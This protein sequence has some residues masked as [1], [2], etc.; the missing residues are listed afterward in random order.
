ELA[1]V[2]TTLEHHALSTL[3][4]CSAPVGTGGEQC[5]YLLAVF[6]EGAFETVRHAVREALVHHLQ[7]SGPHARITDRRRDLTE[8][9]RPGAPGF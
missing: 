5:E 6:G 2:A 4:S 7:A 1:D 9:L 8:L 3:Q